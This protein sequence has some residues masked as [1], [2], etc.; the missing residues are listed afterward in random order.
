MTHEHRP[1]LMFLAQG[2]EGLEISLEDAAFPP[3]LLEVNTLLRAG[4]H[5]EARARLNQ[6]ALAVIDGY[7]ADNPSRT[8]IMYIAARLLTET[9]Q[10]DKAEALLLTILEQ[11]KHPVVSA[12]LAQLLEQDPARKSEAITHWQQACEMAPTNVDYL[13]AYAHCA[14]DV[15][16]V[17]KS[18]QLLEKAVGLAPD[19]ETLKGQL[20]WLMNYLPEYDRRDLFEQAKQ[21][22]QAFATGAAC[23]ASFSDRPAL[24]KR[25][26]IGLVSGD[27]L[28]NSPLRYVLPALTAMNR[29]HFELY[30]YSNVKRS[31]AATD[32]FGASFDVLRDI[33]V[34][35]DPAAAALIRA[36]GIDILIAFGGNCGSNRLGVFT[37][38]PA[39]VQVDWGALSTLGF[40]QIDYRLTDSVLDPPD[41]QPFHTEELVYLSG[42]GV[43]YQPPRESPPVE[44]LPAQ[45]NGYVTFGSFNN[46]MKINDLVLDLWSHIL[47]RVP[48]ARMVIKSPGLY[49]PGIRKRL[50][51]GFQSRGIAF[52]RIQFASMMDHFD[53]LRLVGQVDM[54]LDCYPFTGFRTTLEGLWMGVPAI[55]MSGTTFTSRAGLAILK[56]LGLDEAFAVQTPQAYI[57]R[58]CSYAEQLAEL[59][60]IRAGLRE[61]LLSSSI[62]DPQRCARSLEEAF[63]YMWRQRCDGQKDEQAVGTASG[64]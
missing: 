13:R 22:T 7:M 51:Q 57:D 19:D 44:P 17:E 47:Q 63:Q 33:H 2:T 27:F 64:R 9:G 52:E 40:P 46:H 59:A 43:T 26:R 42:G 30:A 50:E 31:N 35:P 38:K 34:C 24:T 54:L 32:Q 12:D 58:A 28:D 10:A 4:K 29:D 18:V 21:W 8:D 49:D 53:H 16:D 39:P 60:C 1:R 20:L 15:G 48:Q 11:E 14:R 36:D 41:T 61:L 45:A 62:C 23:F 56:Q 6:A 37:L 25:L 55:T 3:V 5:G